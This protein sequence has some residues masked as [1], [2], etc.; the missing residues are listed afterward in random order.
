MIA[1]ISVIGTIVLF[2]LMMKLHHKYPTP[3]LLPVLTTTTVIAVVLV[4]LHIPYEDYMEGADWISKFL[5]PAIVGLAF[6]LYNQRALVYKYKLTIISGLIIAMIA[7]LIS[8]FL[9]LKF[10]KASETYIL[11]ALPKS[12]TTPVAME[13]SSSLG[14]VSAL[15]VVLVMLAGFTGAFL[16]PLIFKLCRI[17]T[18]ISR[19]LAIGAA[20]HGVG[21]SKLVDYGEEEVSIG[22]LS[23]GLS[24]VI[25]AF[26]CPL[27]ANLFVF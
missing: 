13:I 24:A 20:S 27:F 25:G 2:F 10:G 6:P 11:T 8:V 16:G 21:I 23:M 5:G 12:I 14:G 9:L 19:G 1:F 3:L 7:G 26:V 17:D 4:L 15:T 18:A 22:S